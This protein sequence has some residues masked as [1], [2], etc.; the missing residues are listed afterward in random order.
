MF[1][2][3][4]G[5]CLRVSKFKISTQ[6]DRSLRDT[7]SRLIQSHFG[8]VGEDCMGSDV[9]S[10]LDKILIGR[11]VFEQMLWR[12]LL[13]NIERHLFFWKNLRHKS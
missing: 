9:L 13:K 10:A 8:L 7:R 4:K 11:K 6:D 2:H 5:H 3:K 1:K 12:R